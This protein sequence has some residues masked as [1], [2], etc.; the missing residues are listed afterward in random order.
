[1]TAS[2]GLFKKYSNRVF[3][4]TGSFDGNGVQQALDEGFKVAYTIEIVPVLY[5]GTAERFKD[6]PDV[7]P[8]LGDSAKLLEV[9][10]KL[11]DEPVTF[12]LDAHVGASSTPIMKELEIIKNHP[13]KNHTILIDDLRDWKIKIN[14]VNT[15][16]FKDKILEI[17]P[18][19]KFAL[20]DG[21]KPNDVLVAYIEGRKN[22]V[23]FQYFYPI[24]VDI[25]TDKK[26]EVYIDRIP[27]VPVAEDEIRILMLEE[28]KRNEIYEFA[29]AHPEAY[30]HLITYQQELLDSIPK[31]RKFLYMSTWIKGYKSPEK[32]FSV[33][34]VVGGKSDKTVVGYGLRH[35]LWRNRE[36]IT[37]PR[38]FYLSGNAPNKHVF[39]PWKGADYKGQLVLGDSKEP[40]FDSM[41]HIAIESTLI[42]NY[43][44]EKLLDCFQSK[45]VPIY[46]GCTN[47]EEYFN[48]EGMFRVNSID[49][50]V[51][52]CNQLTPEVYESMLPAI[53]ENYQKSMAYCEHEKMLRN[54]ILKV[55]GEYSFSQAGQDEWVLSL[56][57]KDHKG[58]FME[59]GSFMPDELNNTM[60]LEQKG[61]DGISFDIVDYSNKWVV[62]KSK[63]VCVD[64][65]TC[66]FTKYKLPKVIDYLSVDIDGLGDNFAVLKRVLEQGFE[67]K[68]ITVE[69]NRYLGET[70]RQAEMHP[71]RNL[72][73]SLGYQVAKRD[74]HS[75]T[76]LLKIEDWWINPK[77]ITL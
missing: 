31:A 26:V 71:Q 62:R 10:M 66:D 24:S 19:Y 15:Q 34:T 65:L 35:D 32:T 43:F 12:W 55:I 52:V 8:L 40:L 74:V 16:M 4:E 57:P 29:K 69:H 20:E 6:N 60:L 37:I 48:T 46:W 17:N 33:S 7:H 54:E 39:K 45:T 75:N 59:I 36:R 58:S 63:F 38:Q 2:K 14:K 22:K 47:I 11:I 56:F 25:D 73:D 9:V 28:P 68:C 18:N 50:I 51:E 41:F 13:I 61:W 21:W 70:Y 76:N 44:S 49:E 3:I 1:M 72:L 42:K 67:F 23:K 77:Y 53:E 5:Q 27:E 64:A 30:T